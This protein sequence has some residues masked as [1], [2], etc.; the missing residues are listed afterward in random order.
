M[1]NDK[2]NKIKKEILQNKVFEDENLLVINKNIN[3]AVQGGSK[4]GL[5]LDKILN[6]NST[7]KYRLLHR[8]EKNTSGIVLFAKTEKF[9]RIISQ[10]FQKRNIEKTYL[11]IVVGKPTKRIG[12]IKLPIR[13]EK[14]ILQ[15]AET[16]Y[17]IIDN[18]AHE[19]S[20][21]AAYP[22]TG[23]KH[24]LRIHF[25]A[26]NCPILGDGKYGGRQAFKNNL[27]NKIHLHNYRLIIPNYYGK[28]PLILKA[29]LPQLFRST[30]DDLGFDERLL[31]V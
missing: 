21:I 22:I 9:A 10:Y 26:I 12:S 19:L 4:V 1:S 23:R 24:Q 7:I 16:R 11:T 2:L 5:S 6:Y 13:N 27:S 15:K 3:L 14:N 29:S 8:I 25:N 17:E 28:K 30:M 31:D 18:L 20:F